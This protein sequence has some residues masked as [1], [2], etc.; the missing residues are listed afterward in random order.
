MVA[1]FSRLVQ[2]FFVH[3]SILAS[4]PMIELSCVLDEDK[5]GSY[6]NVCLHHEPI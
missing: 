3:E 5:V 4:L 2:L 1:T 6:I